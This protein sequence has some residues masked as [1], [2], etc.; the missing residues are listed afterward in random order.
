MGVGLA[1]WMVETKAFAAVC[2]ARALIPLRDLLVSGL[3]S[4]SVVEVGCAGVDGHPSPH[5]DF[6][7]RTF[8]D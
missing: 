1:R 3:C 5:G 2:A 6:G 4:T 8:S 7:A